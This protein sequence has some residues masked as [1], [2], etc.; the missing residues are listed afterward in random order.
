MIIGSLRECNTHAE[1]DDLTLEEDR[2][3]WLMWINAAAPSMTFFYNESERLFY[4]CRS[5]ER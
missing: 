4:I 2:F 5:A 1:P 3:Y